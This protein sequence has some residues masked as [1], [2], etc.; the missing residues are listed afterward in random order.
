MRASTVVSGRPCRDKERSR[1]YR[2]VMETAS[3]RRGRQR[4]RARTARSRNVRRFRPHV[5]TSTDKDMSAMP[6]ESQSICKYSFAAGTLRRIATIGALCLHATGSRASNP[7]RCTSIC[8]IKNGLVDRR[9]QAFLARAAGNVGITATAI[10]AIGSRGGPR[11]RSNGFQ[12]HSICLGPH[13]G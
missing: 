5:M 8:L 10:A 7:I 2:A 9:Q 6:P 11:A 13:R 12:H 4:D 1:R 3:G